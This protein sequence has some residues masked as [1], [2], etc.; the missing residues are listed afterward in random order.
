MVADSQFPTL[1][2]IRNRGSLSTKI[3]KSGKSFLGHASVNHAFVSN[4]H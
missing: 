2:R 3:E 1:F 4:M